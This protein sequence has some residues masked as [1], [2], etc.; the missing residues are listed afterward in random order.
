MPG[1]KV[2]V[3]KSRKNNRQKNGGYAPVTMITSKRTV[4]FPYPGNTLLSEAA[5]MVGFAWTYRLNSL[6]DPDFTST[7]AQPLGYDQFSALYG[8]YA[9]LRSRFNC[10]FTNATSLP[11]RVGFYLSPQSTLPGSSSA[12]TM[13][14]FGKSATV[15]A[16]GSGKDVVM[17]SGSTS[18]AKELGVTLRQ[19]RDE[20]D[21]SATTS[22]SPARI[23]YLH[24]Y[25]FG[26][27][28]AGN[29][30]INCFVNLN[31]DSEL[32]QAVSQTSS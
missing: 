21:F 5:P 20:A 32:S 28:S 2:S 27:Y 22:A 13:Q 3:R 16:L 15:G 26:L 30:T 6:F 24:T 18:F 4:R 12:W 17:L 8:R 14:P 10:T 9:V 7:G 1:K 23:L 11:A 31:M 29:A 19:Y 25:A